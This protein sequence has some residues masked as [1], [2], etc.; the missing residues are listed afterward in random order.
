MIN[1]FILRSVAQLWL[2][3][4]LHRSWHVLT[5][6]TRALLYS[7][8]CRSLDSRHY[9]TLSKGSPI[10]KAI[11]KNVTGSESFAFGDGIP[12]LGV[13]PRFWTHGIWSLLHLRT[14]KHVCIHLYTFVISDIYIYILL[15]LSDVGVTVNPRTGYHWHSS[16]LKPQV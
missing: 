8:Q 1:T 4:L 5:I 9:T 14:P 12:W 3:A 2:D 7:W 10:H 16:F 15:V 13:D 6:Q 11:Q